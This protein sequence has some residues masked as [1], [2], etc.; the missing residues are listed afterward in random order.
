MTQRMKLLLEC[1]HMC[2]DA[3]ACVRIFGGLLNVIP[4]VLS[5]FG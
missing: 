2:M 4:Q 5:T 1:V 3:H